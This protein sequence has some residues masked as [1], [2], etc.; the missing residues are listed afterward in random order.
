MTIAEAMNEAGRLVGGGQGLFT[1]PQCCQFADILAGVD[2]SKG[3]VIPGRERELVRFF[4][5][6]LRGRKITQKMW[7][8]SSQWVSR[9]ETN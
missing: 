5:R 7:N 9:P 4:C 1:L 6:L 3:I 2:F 8:Q